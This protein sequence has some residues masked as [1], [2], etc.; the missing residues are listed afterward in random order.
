MSIFHKLKNTSDERSK[1]DVKD[2]KEIIGVEQRPE[3]KK[4]RMNIP[5][6]YTA[7]KCEVKFP[8]RIG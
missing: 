8:V 4:V 7:I 2:M 5:R 3:R 6:T 1:C